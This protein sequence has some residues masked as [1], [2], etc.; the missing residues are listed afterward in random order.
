MATKQAADSRAKNEVEERAKQEAE[1]RAKTQEAEDRAKTHEAEARAKQE[2]EERAKKEAEKRTKQEKEAKVKQGAEARAQKLGEEKRADGS[3]EAHVAKSLNLIDE[4]TTADVLG[5]FAD[6][7]LDEYNA[8]V[9][10][11]EVDGRM[12]QEL[13]VQ[14][15]LG[16]LGIATTLHVLKI[17]RAVADPDWRMAARRPA[18]AATHTPNS[19]ASPVVFP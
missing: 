15:A 14:D 12:L 8:A 3:E 17:K 18:Q 11:H 5:F 16:D 7:K 13:L 9:A 10:E 2:V 19:E 6:L 1:D 4:W